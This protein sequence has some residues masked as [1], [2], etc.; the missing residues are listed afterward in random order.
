MKVAIKDFAV[1]MEVKYRGIEFE[2][3][4]NAGKHLGDLVV[5]QTGLTWCNGRTTQ[6]KG[7]KLSWTD[8]I[9]MVNGK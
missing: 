5:T 1:N 4:D 6:K 8:F 2:V 3:K 7:H 9:K